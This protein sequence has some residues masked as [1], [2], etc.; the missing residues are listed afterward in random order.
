MSN[1][2]INLVDHTPVDSDFSTTK[3]QGSP[4]CVDTTTGIAYF[5]NAGTITALTGSSS[6]VL[7]V[8]A[9]S[10]TINGVNTVFTFPTAPASSATLII[11]NGQVLDPGTQYSVTGSTVT[12]TFAPVSGD[13]LNGVFAA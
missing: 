10:G 6:P 8:Q 9:L 4:L 2:W 1:Q 5:N 12:L 11:Y 13:V 7:V 3:G